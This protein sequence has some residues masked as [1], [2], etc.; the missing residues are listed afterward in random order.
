[1]NT[2]IQLIANSTRLGSSL[3]KLVN[4]PES[5]DLTKNNSAPFKEQIGISEKH[6][7]SASAHN[8]GMWLVTYTKDEN[9]EETEKENE[10]SG[11][12]SI[13][14]IAKNTSSVFENIE[15]A[16]YYACGFVNIHTVILKR[17]DPMSQ[18]CEIGHDYCAIK[19]QELPTPEQFPAF[20]YLTVPIEGNRRSNKEEMDNIVFTWRD[21]TFS[22][23]TVRGYCFLIAIVQKN[24]EDD[25]YI[26]EQVQNSP[27]D[28][29]RFDVKNQ[30]SGDDDDDDDDGSDGG[31]GGIVVGNSGY[32][33]EFA[34]SL[35]GSQKD[36]EGTFTSLSVRVSNRLKNN[37]AYAGR[38]MLGGTM[39]AKAP[40]WSRTVS[41]TAD[42]PLKALYVWL[43]LEL[44]DSVVRSGYEINNS[45]EPPKFKETKYGFP[46]YELIG[47]IQD[48]SVRQAH[49]GPVVIT[50]RYYDVQVNEEKS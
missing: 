41:P 38:I 7:T 42:T 23:N 39:L 9:N 21:S 34:L 1:M 5:T 45:D 12:F 43:K 40:T 37:A 31:S 30:N 15:G 50:D 19:R 2:Q 35:T 48:G 17:V 4:T 29:Y 44:A 26:I 18:Y 27:I 24:T 33:G 28:C 11:K 13:D 32:T 6:I 14:W 20:L 22:P 8:S 25:S 16:F 3:Q 47:S 36:E 49:Y 46:Y 10:T